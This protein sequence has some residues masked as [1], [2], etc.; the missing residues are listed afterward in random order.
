MRFYEKS[1]E[2]SEDNRKWVVP[3]T[4]VVISKERG[5][6]WDSFTIPASNIKPKLNF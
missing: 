4:K 2:V 6:H 1:I 3:I 5:Y